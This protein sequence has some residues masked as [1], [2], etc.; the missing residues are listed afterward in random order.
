MRRCS[1]TSAVIAVATAAIACARRFDGYDLNA[2]NAA[3]LAVDA[4]LLYGLHDDNNTC[5]WPVTSYDECAVAVL[6][7]LEG[8]LEVEKINSKRYPGGCFVATDPVTSEQGGFFNSHTGAAIA[9]N[10]PWVWWH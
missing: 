10:A 3:A 1:R 8:V 6:L 5:D 9:R 7:S 2:A 4:T